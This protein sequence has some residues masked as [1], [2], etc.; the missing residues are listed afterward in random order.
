MDN[1]YQKLF[2]LCNEKKL[3]EIYNRNDDFNKFNLGVLLAV[4]QMEYV[5]V[6]VDKQGRSDGIRI[7]SIDDIYR[8]VDESKYIDKYYKI[9]RE[10]E[11]ALLIDDYLDYFNHERCSLES[12]LQYSQDRNMVVSLSL[13]G[14]NQY[15]I[16]GFV[17][18]IEGKIITF[19][20]L[21][22]YGELVTVSYISIDD[23]DYCSCDSEDERILKM[24]YNK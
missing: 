10:F 5:Y 16:S 15:D 11:R 22:T 7:G 19:K 20:E 8:I 1:L 18:A 3:I 4:N 6:F 21:N 12:F 9:M 14:S 24:L 13:C 17:H 23:I 2:S